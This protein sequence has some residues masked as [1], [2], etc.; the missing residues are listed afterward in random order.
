MSSYDAIDSIDF[1]SIELLSPWFQVLFKTGLFKTSSKGHYLF[2][3]L[4]RKLWNKSLNPE[5]LKLVSACIILFSLDV[6]DQDFE[7]PCFSFVEKISNI[8]GILPNEILEVITDRFYNVAAN[9]SEGCRS[10]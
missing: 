8:M 2:K 5:R 9:H 10:Q 7:S 1:G 3:I 6:T 4:M